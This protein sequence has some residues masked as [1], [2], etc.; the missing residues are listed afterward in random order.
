MTFDDAKIDADQ[1]FELQPDPQGVVEY[2][3]K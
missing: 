3:T 2:N 1:E